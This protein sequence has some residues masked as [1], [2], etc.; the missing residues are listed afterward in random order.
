MKNIVY[1]FNTFIELH[2]NNKKMEHF[3]KKN[4]I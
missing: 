2:S 1:L 3:V 4:M